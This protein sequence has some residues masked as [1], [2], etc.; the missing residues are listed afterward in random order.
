MREYIDWLS[1]GLQAGGSPSQALQRV[2]EG[3]HC[4]DHLS[5]AVIFLDD[6]FY[7]VSCL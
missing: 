1:M 5:I 2:P 7:T 6:E 3:A 4:L